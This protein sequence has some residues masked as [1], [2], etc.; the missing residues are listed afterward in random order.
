MR[1]SA[2]VRGLPLARGAAATILLVALSSSAAL[3]AAPV[4]RHFDTPELATTALVA[5]LTANDTKALLG[6]LGPKAK[7]LVDSGDPVA[8]KAAYARFVEKYNEAHALVR[9]G[10]TVT[11]QVGK[12]EWP[13]PIPLVKK[14]DGWRFDDAAG[15]DEIIDRRIG[16]DE[17]SAIQVCLA[18]VDAQREYYARN[19]ENSP[20]LHYAQRIAS[21]PGKRDGLYW[22]TTG[23]QK[24]S[25]LGALF[26][27]A[28][29]EGYAAKGSGEPYHGYYYRILAAQGSHAAGGAY[30]Y[31]AHGEMI[32][33]FALVAYPASYDASGVMT[34][35][36]NQD[37]VV[38]QKDLGPKTAELA[39]A[40]K[41]FDP[42][43]SWTRVEQTNPPDGD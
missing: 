30:D 33:G 3:G 34:F 18:Y 2:A 13:F 43:D 1:S 14:E 12:D 32:G 4:Q 5:A 28:R 29:A 39:R 41:R 31:V 26:A 11:L 25:P 23:D 40:M 22:N 17:L 6:V 21:S 19:P 15:A 27:R 9:T 24:P 10:D 8:D 20:L 37:G 36:V 42:D 38:F 7:P 16:R 35:L